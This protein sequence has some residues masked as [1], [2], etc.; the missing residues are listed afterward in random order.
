[1]AGSIPPRFRP[2]HAPALH[3]IAHVARRTGVSQ[4]ALRSWERRYGP[5]AS[6]RSPSGYRLYTEDDVG[7]IHGIKALLD[8]GFAIGDVVHLSAPE[9][10]ALRARVGSE[11]V[12]PPGPLTAVARERFLAAIDRYDVEEAGRVLA[13]AAI[14]FPPYDFVT[15]VAAPLLVAVG[16]R[17][18]AKTLSVAQ[19][20]AAT[21]M[22]RGQLGDLLRMSRPR[23]G[24]PTVLFTTPA[25]ELHELGALCAAVA[26][27]DAGARVVYLGPNTPDDQIAAAAMRTRADIVGVSLVCLEGR[28]SRTILA[29]IR[30]R[31]PSHVQLWAGGAGVK[32]APPA[33][34]CW[35]PTLAALRTRLAP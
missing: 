28:S 12:A 19:E 26:A 17:W 27:A 1:M 7:R 15:E 32:T 29:R 6:Y 22:L 5:L 13:S 21:A 14:A 18:H 20:H 9:L 24:A 3:R 8:A 33:G 16:D 11:T 25:G 30:R 31:L 34:V 23:R 4:H 2:P 35:V 10:A